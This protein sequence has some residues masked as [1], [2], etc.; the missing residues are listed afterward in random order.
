[1][2]GLTQKRLKELL[3]YDPDSGIFTHKV[4]RGNQVLAGSIAG[5]P[6]GDGHLSTQIDGKEYL[7]HRLAWLYIHGCFPPHQIDHRNLMKADN[8]WGN[9]RLATNSQNSMNKGKQSNNTSGYKGVSFNKPSKK[10]Q[11]RITVNGKRH[12]L[13]YFK[14]VECA[15][16]AYAKAAKILHKEFA[17]V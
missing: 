10:W 17:N 15:G 7:L 9:L 4:Y 2:S 16:K 5:R 11:A 8:R 6:S 12:Y 1:M 14:S 13:G 3:C